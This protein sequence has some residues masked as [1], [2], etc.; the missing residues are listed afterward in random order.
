MYI[1][2]GFICLWVGILLGFIFKAFLTN[3]FEEY[4]GIMYI[5][6]DEERIVYSLVLNEDPETLEF[7]DILIFKVE[8]SE[9]DLVRE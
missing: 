1:L 7:K 4:S 9:E 8:T 2:V 6:K 5:R 3:K